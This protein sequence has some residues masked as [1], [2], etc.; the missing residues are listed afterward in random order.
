MWSGLGTY[1]YVVWSGNILVCGLVWEHTC[2]WSG[3]GTC[4]YVV[5][6]GN[7]LVH[8]LVWGHTHMWSGLGTY[9]YVVW[10]DPYCGCVELVELVGVVH[11]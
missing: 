7:I 6:S 3:L 1:L 11:M 8:G 9:S 4:S 5:W 2:M 10:S